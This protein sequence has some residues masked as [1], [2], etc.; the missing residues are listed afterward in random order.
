MVEELVPI[1]TF[2]IFLDIKCETTAA[3]VVRE[4]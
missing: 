1:Y 3:G 2:S 4:S